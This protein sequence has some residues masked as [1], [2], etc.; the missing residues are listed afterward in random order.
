MAKRQVKDLYLILGVEK[1]S[2]EKEIQRAFRSLSKKWHPDVS[3][4]KD[5]AEVFK[6]IH[7]AYEVL[8]DSE[9]RKGYD[10]FI[11]KERTGKNNK[12]YEEF[13][14]DFHSGI[15]PA[16]APIKGENIEITIPFTIKD[17]KLKAEKSVEFDRFTNCVNCEGH[18][19]KKLAADKCLSCRGSGY[20]LENTDSI[21]GNMK[22]EKTCGSCSGKGYVNTKDC[23]SCKGKGKLND[24]INLK[25]VLPEHTID[26]TRITLTGK[27]DEGLNGG[28]N[29][30]LYLV[31][32][33]DKEDEYWIS[34]TYD[35]NTTVTVPYLNTLTMEPASLT[36]PNGKEIKIP[37]PFGAN[38]GHQ[39]TVPDEGLLNTKNRFYGILTVHLDVETPKVPESLKDPKVKRLIE[40]LS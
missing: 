31:M 9:K 32:E 28:Y 2:T 10:E 11:E 37:I 17:I 30:D 16:Y 8:S 15:Q 18:G 29:G 40:I 6:K 34:N 24:L 14:K 7:E 19:F 4:E 39:I 23:E 26:G 27:G 3:E 36:L 22:V 1:D 35:I 33:H 5:A 12:T 21:F 20:R 38:R 25:F 13:E